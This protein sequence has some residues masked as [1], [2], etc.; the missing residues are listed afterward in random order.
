M[1]ETKNGIKIDVET[2]KKEFYDWFDRF[3]DYKTAS[4]VRKDLFFQ[5]MVEKELNGL[6]FELGCADT[7]KR[8]PALFRPSFKVVIENNQPCFYTL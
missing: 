5:N 4:A 3:F 1:L 8:N 2:A 7:Y 6:T